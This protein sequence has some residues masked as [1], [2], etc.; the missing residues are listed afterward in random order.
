MAGDS[1]PLLFVKKLGMLSPVN[2]AAQ[3]AMNHVQGTVT[4]KLTRATA[5]QK[6]RS[7]YWSIA[8]L[9]AEALSDRLD[10]PIT[11]QDLHDLTRKKLGLYDEI[12]LPSGEVYQRLRSTSDRNMP[13][14]ERAAYTDRAFNVW[15]KWL[16]VEVQTLLEE[17]R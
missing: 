17:G 2:G 1:A 7:L 8:H 9:V 3:E 10:N 13:E 11:E 4:V 15:S 12:P 16:G 6:R 14:P 5:N